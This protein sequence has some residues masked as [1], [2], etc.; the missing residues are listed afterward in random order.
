MSTAMFNELEL[1]QSYLNAS[2]YNVHDRQC[3]NKSNITP[4]SSQSFLYDIWNKSKPCQQKSQY[5]WLVK[6]IFSI[7]FCGLVLI[8]YGRWM[9]LELEIEPNIAYRGSRRQMV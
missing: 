8:V 5:I 2:I 4:G 7:F 6:R 9:T 3:Y 1:T